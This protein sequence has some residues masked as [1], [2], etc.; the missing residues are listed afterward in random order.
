MKHPR[1]YI[2]YLALFALSAFA[3]EPSTPLAATRSPYRTVY[4]NVQDLNNGNLDAVRKI[5]EML[6]DNPSADVVSTTS[7][8][9]AGSTIGIVVVV[10]LKPGENFRG[11]MTREEFDRETKAASEKSR[12]TQ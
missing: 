6:Q 7:I 4:F 2:L 9:N 10:K 12:K 8:S 11:R 5:N 1:L 3:A